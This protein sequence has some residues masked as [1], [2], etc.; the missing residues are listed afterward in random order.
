[1]RQYK[2]Q[3]IQIPILGFVAYCEVEAGFYKTECEAISKYDYDKYL[4]WA[5]GDTWGYSTLRN[6]N[7]GRK[8]VVK[9]PNY[10][11]KEDVVGLCAGLA[12]V[13]ARNMN[14]QFDNIVS[15][16]AAEIYSKLQT[17]E[18]ED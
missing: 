3:I 17:I 12:V 18:V 10:S 2:N 5:Q 15:R 6:E 16:T 14:V 9:L 7:Y 4:D 11:C 1:M 8:I 13:A